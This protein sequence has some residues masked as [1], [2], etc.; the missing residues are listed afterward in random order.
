VTDHAALKEQVALSSVAVSAVLTV[1]KAAAGL[2]SGSLAL[3]SEA[4]HNAIYTGATILT[5]FAVRQANKPADES[6]HYGHGKYESLSA[7]FETGLLAGLA[8]YVLFTAIAR[9]REGGEAVDSSW[10]VFGVLIVSIVADTGRYLTLSSVAKKTGSHALAA[11]AMHFASD[12]VGSVLVLIGLIANHYGFVQGDALAAIGVALFVGYAG[13]RLGGETLGTLLD[14]APEGLAEQLSDEIVQVPGVVAVEN[15][16]LRSNGPKIA[17]EVF[18]AVARSLPLERVAEIE[19]AVREKISEVSPQTEATVS[20]SPRAL[21]DETLA[22]RIVMI[23]ARKKLPVHHIFVHHLGDR[24]CI[25]F[26]LEVDGS[27]PTVE[28]HAIATAL[29]NDIRD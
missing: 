5:Y 26:D 15:I 9:L 4:A 21:D 19:A 28:A 18:I 27:L 3:M 11:D 20:S 14:R 7:L 12:L 10:W 29:E 25:A 1:G 24:D 23:A 16:K 17:G 6:H 8:I 13:V 22:E 2:A